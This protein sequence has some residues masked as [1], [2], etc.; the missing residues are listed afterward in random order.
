M[1][2]LDN[3]FLQTQANF[4]LMLCFVLTVAI[5]SCATGAMFFN[6]LRHNLRDGDWYRYL[7]VG[8]EYF[9]WAVLFLCLVFDVLFFLRVIQAFGG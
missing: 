8:F 9:A 1:V 4:S 7:A 5:V 3:L 6:V 2:D